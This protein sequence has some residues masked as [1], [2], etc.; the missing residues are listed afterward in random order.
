MSELTSFSPILSARAPAWVFVNTISSPLW[1]LAPLKSSSKS[2]KESKSSSWIQQQPGYSGRAGSDSFLCT[3]DHSKERTAHCSHCRAVAGRN[4][5]F[6]EAVKE[7]AFVAEGR[8]ALTALRR[9]S[10]LSLR[11]FEKRSWFTSPLVI[12]MRT[13]FS[14]SCVAFTPGRA[15][16]TFRY[17]SH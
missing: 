13:D 3:E 17:Q 15:S 7:D 14:M 4:A 1:N 2:P 16:T 10:R 6:S 11:P 9:G 8:R 12:T 5:P